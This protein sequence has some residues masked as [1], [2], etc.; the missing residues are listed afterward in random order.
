M[1]KAVRA[2]TCSL[3]GVCV[4]AGTTFISSAGSTNLPTAGAGGISQNISYTQKLPEA[5][6]S[7]T[8][9]EYYA[10]A[11]ESDVDV[12]G[13]L[14]PSVKSEYKDIV[15][16]QVDN[17]VNIRDKAGEDGQVLGKL[18]NE[19]AAEIVGE[20]GEWYEITSGTVTGYVKK[21]FVV[22]GSEAEELAERVGNKIATVN[23]KTLKVRE[24]ASTD[25]PI[26]TLVPEQEELEVLEV[27][28][29]WTKIA[30]DNDV[31]GFV[32][33]DYV[34]VRTEFVQA[35]SL[36]EE[37]ARLQREEEER[38]EA[39]RAAEEAARLADEAAKAEAAAKE[40]AEKE[41]A[42]KDAA[43]KEAAAK[44]KA[45]K[46]KAA[47]EAAA[48]EKEAKEKAAKEEAARQAAEQAA[49]DSQVSSNAQEE[50][51]TASAGSTETSGARQKIVSY[52]LQFVGNPYVYGGTSLTNGTDC[53][54]FT[55]SVY[56]DCG[57]SIPR[58]SRSQASSGREVSL[59][60]LKPGDLIFYSKGG[61]INHV[62]LYIGNN[63][64][65]H[66]S[67]AKTGI[68]ISN[69]NYRTPV[70]AVSYLD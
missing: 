18:Y 65:V 28:D 3:A 6:I 41:K 10:A 17:Y 35:E 9:N 69:Y 38:L 48:K 13:N 68:K 58:D 23:T 56:R 11:P 37:A 8:L 29:G 24:S 34:E 1:K 47:K 12:I 62:A 45:A 51:K 66:A 42:A 21:E 55:M 59:D 2:L 50:T 49:Q 67:T 5:G 40:A 27:L 19:S 4:I 64:V 7:L 15:I 30:V 52:A 43:A 61:S 39:Q 70:K 20:D 25:S 32:A 46:E 36:A 16:A 44:E 57:Y 22:V 26:L 14:V 60:E 31:V 33:N 53:S 54:G 63:Q